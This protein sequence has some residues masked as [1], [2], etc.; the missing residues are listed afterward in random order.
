MTPTLMLSCAAAVVTPA[1]KTIAASVILLAYCLMFCPSIVRAALA[2]LVAT[3]S[4]R[5]ISSTSYAKRVEPDG[6]RAGPGRQWLSWWNDN[7]GSEWPGKPKL[8]H[9]T[10][11][12][13]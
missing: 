8:P 13:A 7:M 4:V 11:Q 6:T 12:I 3:R 1:A 10:R 9:V 2:D 5:G